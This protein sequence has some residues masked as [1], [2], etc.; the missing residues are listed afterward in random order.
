MLS[1]TLGTRGPNARF[2]RTGEAGRA[3]R[4]L[5]GIVQ[6]RDSGNAIMIPPARKQERHGGSLGVPTQQ[7]VYYAARFEGARPR[8]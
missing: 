6:S 2:S 1:P 5:I 7:R 8:V 3:V 4:G